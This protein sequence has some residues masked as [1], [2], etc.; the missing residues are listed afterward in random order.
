FGG[1]AVIAPR[2]SLAASRWARLRCLDRQARD[3]AVVPDEGDC[4]GDKV[5]DLAVASIARVTRVCRSEGVADALRVGQRLELV[6]RVLL[7]LADPLARH[8]ERLADLPERVWA[9]AREPEAH[10]DHLA[11]PRRQRPHHPAYVL[12]PQVLRGDLERRLGGL[13]L[14]EV[15]QLGLLFLAD[16]LLE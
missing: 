9:G 6:E 13:V 8:V 3:A 11:L 2:S 5:S 15:A 1:G 4:D 14:D 7:D 12:A 10:L 16:R